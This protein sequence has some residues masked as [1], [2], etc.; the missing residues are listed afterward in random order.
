MSGL[1]EHTDR[2]VCTHPGWAVL[3]GWGQVAASFFALFQNDQHLQ[4]ILTNIS[5]QSEGGVAWVSVD[6]N[7]L[8]EAEPVTT[9]AAL[10]VFVGVPEGGWRMVAHHASPVTAEADLPDTGPDDPGGP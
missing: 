8:A 5:A 2:V 10:N 6:E 1:W 4:F 3:R 7:I 9:V